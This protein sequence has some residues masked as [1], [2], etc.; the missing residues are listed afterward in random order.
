MLAMDVNDN[1]RSQIP[2][3][4]GKSIASMRAPT[5]GLG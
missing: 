4:A 5:G 2:S 1:A 3:G